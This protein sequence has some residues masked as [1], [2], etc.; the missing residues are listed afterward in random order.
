MMR[1]TEAP[2]IRIDLGSDT[3]TRPSREMLQ[4]MVSAP[5]G[6]EQLG[7]DP[8]TRALEERTA[9]LLGQ[10]SAVFL[11]SGTMCNQ[12]AFLVHCRPGDEVIAAQQ[13]HIYGSEGAGAA[14]LAGAFVRPIETRD[15]IFDGQAVARAVRPARIRAPRSRVVV[16][17]QTSNR[18]GGAVWPLDLVG[19]VAARA[20]DSGLAMHMDGARLFNAVVASSVDAPAFGRVCDSIWIDFSKGLGCPVG[21]VLAGPRDFITE[22]WRWKHRLGG[23]MRQS[24]V[25]AAACLYALD[26]NIA[27]LAQDHDNARRFGDLV[28]QLPGVRLAFPIETNIVFVDISG[29]GR[30]A[31]DVAAGLRGRGV[32]LSLEGPRVLRAVTH[33]DI[34]EAD[35][36]PAAHALAAAIESQPDSHS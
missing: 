20:R 14:A 8:T 22:A 17:E 7:E 18:G 15:G 30:A 29:T 35:I 21:A 6:D 24:G 9:H 26:R 12:I 36:E 28:S 27:R 13:S 2:I 5:V 4:A 33:L 16:V 25:L 34:G 19:D 3:A 32:R 10:E 1:D 11:P 23:A 31:P